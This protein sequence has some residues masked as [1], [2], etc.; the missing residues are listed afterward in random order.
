MNLQQ[1]V[2]EILYN[3]YR[4]KNQLHNFYKDAELV[5]GDRY[6]EYDLNLKN[7]NA[8]KI[9]QAL[10]RYYNKRHGYI[11]HH[12]PYEYTLDLYPMHPMFY[13]IIN[14]INKSGQWIDSETYKL[15]IEYY[16]PIQDIDLFAISFGQD[17]HESISR[18]YPE[19]K[20]F[21]NIIPLDS[22]ARKVYKH[23]RRRIV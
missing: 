18:I 7:R 12:G 10:R 19:Y 3:D 21:Y 15:R 6:K 20:D 17:Y 8:K 2:Y 22:L 11:K 4:N 5:L 1:R 13:K 14:H 23:K 9:Q 16:G